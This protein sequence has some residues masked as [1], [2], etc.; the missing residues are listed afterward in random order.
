LKLKAGELY[1]TLDILLIAKKAHEKI[2]VSL[3]PKIYWWSLPVLTLLSP[4]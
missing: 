3:S 4:E 1:E 2:T